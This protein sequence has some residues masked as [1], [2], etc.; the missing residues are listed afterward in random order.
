MSLQLIHA[1][2]GEARPRD[3]EIDLFGLTHPGKVRHDNQDHFL[4]CTL[5][6][7][8]VV[9][10][11]SLGALESVP[12]Q[13]ERLG[14]VAMVADGVGGAAAGGEASRLAVSAVA[15]YVSHMLETVH[16]VDPTDVEA[17][18]AELRATMLDAHDAV[19]E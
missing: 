5:H 15:R 7:Q 17:V 14:T 13:G 19:Q 16:K 1:N 2:D 11:S 4:L 9:H 12:L 10:A 18:S 3:T 8:L 6:R